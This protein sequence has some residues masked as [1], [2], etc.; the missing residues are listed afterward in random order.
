MIDIKKHW[1]IEPKKVEELLIDRNPFSKT[2]Q[3]LLDTKYILK[4]T[5]NEPDEMLLEKLEMADIPVTEPIGNTVKKDKYYQLFEY[6]PCSGRLDYNDTELAAALGRTIG[7]ISK[8]DA[9]DGPDLK[10][11]LYEIKCCI[12][13]KSI[14]PLFKH[15]EKHLFPYLP[16][17]EKNFS[18]GDLHPSNILWKNNKLKA[19]IDWEIAAVREELYDV[20]F[21]LGNVGMDDP[22]NLKSPWVK[23]LLQSIKES[24][25]TK[26]GFSLLPELML[27]TRVPW[28]YIW[29]QRAKDTQIANMESEY[30]QIILKNIEDIRSLWLDWAGEFKYTMNNWVMQDAHDTKEIEKAKT[31]M[32]GKDLDNLPI[33][34]S[35][36]LSADLRQL[37]IDFGMNDD[38]LNLIKMIEL[39]KI[40][41]EKYPEN[42]QI[43]VE[44]SLTLGNAT[45]D[46]SKFQ[47]VGGM[48]E[49]KK[50][51]EEHKKRHGKIDSVSIG[52]AFLLR[53][54]SI[55]LAEL[56]RV[57]ES[58]CLIEEQINYAKKNKHIEI[59]GELARTLSN[60]ITTCLSNRIDTLDRYFM[61]LTE[62][63]DRYKSKKISVAYQVAR[64]NIKKADR[65]L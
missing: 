40:L 3:W 65:F 64:T 53:N 42:Q 55:M 20:A 62:L 61:L 49:I 11:R 58:L 17:Y 19:V 15:L 2:K 18:H 9:I 43:Q 16:Y 30:W 56:G 63:N 23:A 13:N 7:K 24:K 45:L 50:Q 51:Y 41:S 44:R 10:K 38:I 29:Q 8:V 4:A 54:S 47:L 5:E 28:M 26:L 32:K 57:D 60:G 52:Y 1:F 21:L 48:N 36:E 31:R 22:N 25:P 12:K 35:E 39:Q 14:A 37:A 33:T 6:I 27:A 59:Q 34:A 46:M